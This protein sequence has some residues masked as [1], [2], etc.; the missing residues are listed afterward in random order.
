MPIFANKSPVSPDTLLF[1][2]AFS[3]ELCETAALVF[4]REAAVPALPLNALELFI[5]AESKADDAVLCPLDAADDERTVLPDEKTL[6]S[7]TGDVFSFA[8]RAC[9][10]INCSILFWRGTFSRRMAAFVS[11]FF[12]CAAEDAAAEEEAAGLA[13]FDKDA[14]APLGE[15]DAVSVFCAG[16]LR[17]AAFAGAL[18]FC[19]EAA[20]DF[21]V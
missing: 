2:C 21:A 16:A 8:V 15:E 5:F 14:D 13:A 18:A 4:S 10:A 20:V 19:A 17:E 6:S 1:V 9:S 12:A 11:A 7:Q 3:C